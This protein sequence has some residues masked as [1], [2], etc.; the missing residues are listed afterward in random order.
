MAAKQMKQTWVICQRKC[1]KSRKKR[2]TQTKLTIRYKH[3][4][5]TDVTVLSN[6]TLELLDP[7]K[8]FLISET[9]NS[10][11]RRTQRMLETSL[12]PLSE[13]NGKLAPPILCIILRTKSAIL[14]ITD[15][16]DSFL[17]IVKLYYIKNKAITNTVDVT[18]HL[19]LRMEVR[20][21]A[22]GMDHREKNILLTNTWKKE[23]M[24]IN[25]ANL[26]HL[27]IQGTGVTLPVLKSKSL[28]GIT[29]DNYDREH[30]VFG[31]CRNVWKSKDFQTKTFPPSY[32]LHIIMMYYEESGATVHLWQCDQEFT[33]HSQHF[34][35]FQK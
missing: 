21:C 33:M 26:N 31:W 27:K 8:P 2:M 12:K 18:Q 5:T 20:D 22:I 30:L 11:M 1:P 7:I 17:K 32:L 23:I 9:V 29:D 14:T 15:Q 13:C 19:R 35:G 3:K 6:T 34:L 16:K 4:M 24:V 10:A 25:I 28:I